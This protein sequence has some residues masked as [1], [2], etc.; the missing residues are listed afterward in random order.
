MLSILLDVPVQEESFIS[1]NSN[2]LLVTIAVL[3]LAALVGIFIWKKRSNK[4]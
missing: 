3:A 4:P 2:V 1:R